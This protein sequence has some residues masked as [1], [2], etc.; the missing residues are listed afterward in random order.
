[1]ERFNCTCQA[2]VSYFLIK[3]VNKCGQVELLIR[4]VL[5]LE[6]KTCMFITSVNS[7]MSITILDTSSYIDTKTVQVLHLYHSTRRIEKALG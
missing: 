7:V 4:D 3:N 2:N 1:M 6:L 5:F